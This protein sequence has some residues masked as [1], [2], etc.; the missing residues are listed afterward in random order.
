MRIHRT[1]DEIRE[2]K[3]L[4]V[5][6]RADGDPH[7]DGEVSFTRNGEHYPITLANLDEHLERQ[8]KKGRHVRR[9]ETGDGGWQSRTTCPRWGTTYWYRTVATVSYF[10]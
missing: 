9:I 5:W 10:I 6:E 2:Q 4:E 7:S 1:Y 3:E 8:E